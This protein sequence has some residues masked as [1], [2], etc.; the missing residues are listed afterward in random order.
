M[1]SL[2]PGEW[3]NKSE[4]GVGTLLRQFEAAES[5]GQTPVIPVEDSASST[6]GCSLASGGAVLGP[7]VR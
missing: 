1:T 7:R 5:A 6:F 3:G 2:R 4:D